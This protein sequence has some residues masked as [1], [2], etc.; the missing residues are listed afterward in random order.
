M[1]FNNE[2]HYNTIIN[3]FNQIINALNEIERNDKNN[4]NE[5]N[6]RLDLLEQKNR[7]I[8]DGLKNILENI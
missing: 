1:L 2:C 5:I 8:K 7:N 4:T 6:T 3:S